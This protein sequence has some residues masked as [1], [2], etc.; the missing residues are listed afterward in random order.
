[1]TMMNDYAFLFA[2]KLFSCGWLQKRQISITE[3][4]KEVESEEDS[5]ENQKNIN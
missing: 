3:I 1:M 2:R 4:Q 5:E